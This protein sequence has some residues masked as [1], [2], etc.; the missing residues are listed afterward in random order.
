MS[1]IYEV[2]LRGAMNL[3][4][5][6]NAFHYVV[7]DVLATPT[8]LNLL[9]LMGFI[10]TGDPPLLPEDTL[11]ASLR[12]CVSEDVH[13]VEVEAREMYSVTDFYTAPYSPAVPG[14]QDQPASSPVLA[15]GLRSNRV[16]T[17]VRRGYKRLP[18]VT[19]ANMDAGGAVG[20]DQLT[21][22]TALATAMSATLTGLGGPY[23]PAVLA[24]EEYTTPR[25]RSAY[26][27]Y[28]TRDEQLAHAAYAVSWQPYDVVRT[29][30]SRQYGRGI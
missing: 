12:A 2:T 13:F 1:A 18:G 9:T 28:A 4:A 20:A 14:I 29:Q 26:K 10:P 8:A 23:M 19:E 21:V 25:G 15:W 27:P 22:L 11:F 6:V 5:T 16:R 17:D 24:F 7:T 30:N 3:Q